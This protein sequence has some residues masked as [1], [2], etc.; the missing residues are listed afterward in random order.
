MCIGVNWFKCGKLL[1]IPFEVYL[2]AYHVYCLLKNIK[3]EKGVWWDIRTASTMLPVSN[4][5]ANT[6]SRKNWATVHNSA[7]PAQILVHCLTQAHMCCFLCFNLCHID[8]T[9]RPDPAALPGD[10][11]SDRWPFVSNN[12]IAYGVSAISEVQRSWKIHCYQVLYA[13]HESHA[14][15]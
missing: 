10:C 11:C 8:V 12:V 7:N 5:A 2:S 3:E 14:S 9:W 15:R 6:F 4:L 1:H 13:G